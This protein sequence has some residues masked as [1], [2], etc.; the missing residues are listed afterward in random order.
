MTRST[1]LYNWDSVHYV[2]AQDRY[3]LL[4][5]QPWPAEGAVAPAARRAV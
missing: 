2:L 4:A 3:D 5:H 1:I